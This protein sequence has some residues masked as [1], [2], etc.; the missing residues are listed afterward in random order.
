MRTEFVPQRPF[1]CTFLDDRFDQQYRAYVQ[2]GQV[3]GVVAG[4]A[5]VVACLGLLGLATFTVQQRRKEVGVRRVLC[6]GVAGLVALRSREFLVLVGSAF[7][8]AAPLAYVLM[9]RWQS[10]FAYRVD[11]GP[12]TLA[13]A[14]GFALAVALATAALATVAAQ[15]FRAATADPVR[16]LQSE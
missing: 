15:A 1:T 16:S 7:A 12:G 5:V 13:L 2:F 10:G 6:A 4:L 9:D 11:V 3:F 8:F 14:G